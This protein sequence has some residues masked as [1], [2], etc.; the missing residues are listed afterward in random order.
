MPGQYP[1]VFFPGVMGSRLHFENSGKYWDPDSAWLMRLWI[2]VWPFRSD[3]DNRRELHAREPAGVM[4]DP[5][6]NQVDAHGV[7]HGWGGVVWSF[8]KDYL[9]HLRSLAANQDA[10]A[11]GYDWRQDIAWLGEYAA[12]KLRACLD[13]TGADKLLLAAHSMGGLVVRAA[14]LFAPDLVHRIDKVLYICQP[15]VGAVV[16]YRRLFTGLTAN[17]DGQGSVSNWLFRI[18]L[19]N[20]R[21]GFV[22]NMSGQPGPLELLPSAFF[23]TNAGLHWHGSLDAGLTHNALY[24]NNASPPG[25]NDLQLTLVAEA[26][27]DLLE[28]IQDI[29]D[30]HGWLGAPAR[31]DV[32]WPD[33]WLIY[34]TGRATETRIDFPGGAP[35]PG[36]TP[37]GDG[38]VPFLSATA[39]GLPGDRQFGLDSL[40]HSTACL[41]SR[42]LDV[43]TQL[44]G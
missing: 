22:G 8:Y 16:L 24:N 38:T 44:F 6:D 5:L 3:E 17:L 32:S 15:S 36:V 43:T 7:D 14:L 42:V 26:R 20:S 10:F 23:P 19:G 33:S 34:G 11:V 25:L 31:T 12:G 13:H 40:E 28:R 37:E 41:D 9:D 39:L 4:I 35:Q 1:I 30:F 2:P 27:A 18:L 21:A 29:A